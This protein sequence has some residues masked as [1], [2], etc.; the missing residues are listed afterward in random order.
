[1]GENIKRYSCSGSSIDLG[2]GLAEHTRGGGDLVKYSDHIEIVEQLKAERD[3]LKKMD[4][5]YTLFCAKLLDHE[6][7]V[8]TEEGLQIIMSEV[9]RELGWQPKESPDDQ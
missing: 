5:A 2:A 1:M 6:G 4:R 7:A 8:I 9:S 3:E